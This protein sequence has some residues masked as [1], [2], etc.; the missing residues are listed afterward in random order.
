MLQERPRQACMTDL[1]P[2]AIGRCPLRN[3]AAGSIGPHKGD[4]LD[5]RVL[6]NVVDNIPGAM[7]NVEHAPAATTTTLTTL[8]PNNDIDKE[9]T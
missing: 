3:V 2:L 1:H 8:K 7:H 9:S 6:Q 4:C 5:V